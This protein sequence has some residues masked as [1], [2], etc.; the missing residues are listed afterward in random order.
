VCV[1]AIAAVR[2][3]RSWHDLDPDHELLRAE[4]VVAIRTQAASPGSGLFYQPRATALSYEVALAAF[5]RLCEE[6]C[7]VTVRQSAG[8]SPT[9]FMITERDRALPRIPTPE[10]LYA[11]E[12]LAR[13]DRTRFVGGRPGAAGQSARVRHDRT[14]L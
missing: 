1:R 4:V 9:T 13:L 14:Q 12:A 7:I 8:R 11:L 6:C 3:A 2:Q 5:L 10:D